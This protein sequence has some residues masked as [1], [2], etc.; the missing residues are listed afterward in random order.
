MSN[1]SLTIFS[2]YLHHP[3]VFPVPIT[4]LMQM[5]RW[6]SEL[7]KVLDDLLRSTVTVLII[8]THIT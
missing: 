6:C 3:I 1:L 5:I 4:S 7:K 8:V 2:F